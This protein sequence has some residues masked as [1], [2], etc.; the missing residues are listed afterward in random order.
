MNSV[1]CL[2]VF[3]EDLILASTAVF[4][5]VDFGFVSKPSLSGSTAFPL[6]HIC[7]VGRR[8]CVYG[9]FFFF[10]LNVFS[11]LLTPSLLFPST[12][13]IIPNKT[14]DISVA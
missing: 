11:I 4:C 3:L 6:F 9:F 14:K 12:A 1:T 8:L 5:P 2:L 13:T 10:S 7:G